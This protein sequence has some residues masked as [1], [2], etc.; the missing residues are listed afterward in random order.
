MASSIFNNQ[1][2][3][4]ADN[5]VIQPKTEFADTYP[6]IE[7]DGR[8][9]QNKYTYEIVPNHPEYAERSDIL[10]P[11]S[12]EDAEAIFLKQGKKPSADSSKG[13]DEL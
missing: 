2:H 5:P 3:I 8:W 4:Y 6:P 1:I 11:I 10:R 7:H 9:L 13:M 12:D